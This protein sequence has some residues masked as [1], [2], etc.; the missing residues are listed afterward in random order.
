MEEI[1]NISD[2]ISRMPNCTEKICLDL[3]QKLLQHKV[4]GAVNL[5]SE[6]AIENIYENLEHQIKKEELNS[7]S[8]NQILVDLK[9]KT[10]ISDGITCLRKLIK[11]IRPL[12]IQEIVRLV[13]KAAEGNSLISGQDIVL[14]IGETGTGKST[15]IQ[16]LAGCKMVEKRVEVAKDVFID[17]HIEAVSFPDNNP[18]LTGVKSSCLNQSETRY[19]KPVRVNLREVIGP[20]ED[21]YINLC[22]APGY[23]DT[24][25]PEVDIANSIGVINTIEKCTSVKVVAL[26]SSKNSGDRGQGI[27]KLAR[28]LVNLIEDI[29]E[30]TDAIIYLFTKYPI[31]D[32]VNANLVNLKNCI[33]S[34]LEKDKGFMIVINDMIEKTE[35]ETLIIDPI[36]G[37]PKNILKVLKS[38]QGIKFP[39]KVFRYPFSP[40]CL[41]T[42]KNQVQ[43]YQKNISSALKHKNNELALFYLN[44]LKTSNDLIKKDFLNEAYNKAVNLILENHQNYC[45]ETKAKFNRALQSQDGLKEDDIQEYKKAIEFIKDSQIFIDHFGSRI[46]IPSF[47]IQNITVEFQKIKEKLKE[48]LKDESISNPL[49]GVYLDNLF[50]V[51]SSLVHFHANYIKECEELETVANSL[52]S[53]IKELIKPDKFEEFSEKVLILYNSSIVFK[54]HDFSK[55]F[56]EKYI[57]SIELFLAYLREFANDPLLEKRKISE[58][59]VQTLNKYVEYLRSAKENSVLQDRMVLYS[60]LIKNRVN[61]TSKNSNILS[62]IFNEFLEKI[63][64]YFEVI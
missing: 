24:A 45:E 22:D 32:N 59:E 63:N 56:E 34:N 14:F 54:S 52:F 30:R 60:K 61:E 9:S 42:I 25:G 33:Q 13:T 2:D 44:N 39:D 29:E 38:I 49:F 57:L 36:K 8:V 23:G 53:N 5:S 28:L 10:S 3:L 48:K 17:D 35:K 27:Q 16:F 55:N 37:T 31:G 41:S 7:Q 18:T 40:E 50:A 46:I 58:K 4:D 43:R 47:F 12:N 64:D 6:N 19:I 1:N 15:T 62:L 51:S 11:E 21:G 26:L 20:S